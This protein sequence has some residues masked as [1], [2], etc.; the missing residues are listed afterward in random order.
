LRRIL[1]A[2]LATAVAVSILLT[3]W[4]CHQ[5]IARIVVEMADVLA[6]WVGRLLRLHARSY[7]HD[8]V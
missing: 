2:A 4:P 3:I 5:Q 1:T 8:A 6:E 7:A